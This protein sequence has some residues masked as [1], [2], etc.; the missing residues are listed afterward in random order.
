MPVENL[1]A[2]DRVTISTGNIML[3]SCD[4]GGGILPIPTNAN[5]QIMQTSYQSKT[6]YLRGATY[7]RKKSLNL[8]SALLFVVDRPRLPEL[9]HPFK[10]CYP[11]VD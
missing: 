4:H 9:V 8:W 6:T 1:V 11:S 7:L 3:W 5:D 2:Q 10:G